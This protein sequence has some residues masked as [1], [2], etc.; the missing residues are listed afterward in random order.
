MQCAVS[1]DLK[2][3]YAQQERAQ[4]EDEDRSDAIAEC[5]RS[6]LEETPYEVFI[7]CEGLDAVEAINKLAKAKTSLDLFEAQQ[8]LIECITTQAKAIAERTTP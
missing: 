5:A 4:R 1:A 6:L 8:M 3:Y 7:S 2:R